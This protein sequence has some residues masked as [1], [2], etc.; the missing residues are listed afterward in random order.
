MCLP[1][2]NSDTDHDL[3]TIGQSAVAK[4]QRVFACACPTLESKDHWTMKPM[5]QTTTDT[6]QQAP[7]AS[8][9]ATDATNNGI[10][11]RPSS[12]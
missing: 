2:V 12:N 6:F 9:Y 11:N 10:D 7:R 4:A 5:F 3:Y 1:A 8:R